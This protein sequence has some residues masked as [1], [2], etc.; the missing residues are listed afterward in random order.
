MEIG[1]LIL[2]LNKSTTTE[3]ICENEHGVLI[4]IPKVFSYSEP[5]LTIELYYGLYQGEWVGWHK[6]VGKTWGVSYCPHVSWILRF[7]SLVRA[8][9]FQLPLLYHRAMG[10]DWPGQKPEKKAYNNF[11]EKYNQWRNMVI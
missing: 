5:D 11:L 6:I 10:F 2:T 8:T 9:D 7:D 3:G 4:G 1:S